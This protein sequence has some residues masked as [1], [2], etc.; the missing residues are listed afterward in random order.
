MPECFRKSSRR[1]GSVVMLSPIVVWLTRDPAASVRRRHVSRVG[2]GELPYGVCRGRGRVLDGC[3]R[4]RTIE[5]C[6]VEDVPLVEGP[7]VGASGQVVGK[8]AGTLEH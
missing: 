5:H 4:Y 8:M 2:D 1:C 7:T 6:A 3:R